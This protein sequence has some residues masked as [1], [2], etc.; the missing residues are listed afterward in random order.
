MF[1]EGA[2]RLL[3]SEVTIPLLRPGGPDRI[4][5]E[6]YPGVLARHLGYA[7]YKNDALRK[8]TEVQLRAR[9]AMLND[10][11]NG[12]LESRYGLLVEAPASLADDPGGDQLD[13][14]LCAIQAAWAWTMRGERYGAP[15]GTDALEGWI[16]DPTLAASA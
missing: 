4:V 5:V 6:A 1:F 13:A 7:G 9:R 2:R 10:I 3:K 12:R 8:Q 15:Q 16:A 11:L 14:L